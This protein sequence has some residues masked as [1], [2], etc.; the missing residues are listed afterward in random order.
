MCSKVVKGKLT[1]KM[2]PWKPV[3]LWKLPRILTE[4][5]QKSSKAPWMG[6][7]PTG[8]PIIEGLCTSMDRHL[9]KD[10]KAHDPAACPLWSKKQKH[11]PNLCIRSCSSSVGW[12]GLWLSFPHL[13]Q[14]AITCHQ[15]GKLT[16]GGRE[17]KETRKKKER[18]RGVGGVTIQRR[19]AK[20]QCGEQ[21]ASTQ[22]GKHTK[23][24]V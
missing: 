14:K 13:I 2:A 1:E 7:R 21:N 4:R 12:S 15:H 16:G 19:T 23:Y 18:R 11:K 8:R 17:K 3:G 9:L 20:A 10:R 24:D 6:G 5:G 22:L